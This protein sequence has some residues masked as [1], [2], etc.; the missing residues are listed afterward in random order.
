M[1]EELKR[2]CETCRYCLLEDW[3][4]SNYTVEGTNVHCLKKIHPESGFD[5]WYGVD[6]RLAFAE[7]CPQYVKGEALALDC[8]RE[9]LKDYRGPVSQMT[10]DE[11]LK[12][13]LDIWE[14]K[15]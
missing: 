8:D 3:G 11:E 1:S 10:E 12:A 6:K 7:T 15:P 9:V 14:P 4:Y 13:L 5:R 2:S